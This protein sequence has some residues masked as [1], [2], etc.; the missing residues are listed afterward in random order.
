MA[1]T[2]PPAPRGCGDG[3]G[4]EKNACAERRAAQY[5]LQ[6]VAGRPVEPPFEDW[7]VALYDPPPKKDLK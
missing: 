6:Y 1:A 5:I 4:P 2:K 7:E 3:S